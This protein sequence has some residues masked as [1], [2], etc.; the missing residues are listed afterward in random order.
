MLTS[1]LKDT[2]MT[3][4]IL[5]REIMALTRDDDGKVAQRSARS[6]MQITKICD[7]HSAERERSLTRNK[8]RVLLMSISSSL[9]I[10]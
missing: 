7:L 2:I 1:V 6:T 8:Y 9:Q 5:D 4:I 3:L 10:T